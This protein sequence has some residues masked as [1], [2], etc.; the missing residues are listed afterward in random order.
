[1]EAVCED[2]SEILHSSSF[3]PGP[4]KLQAS[5]PGILKALNNRPTQGRVCKFGCEEVFRGSKHRA[6]R[7][8]PA[9]IKIGPARLHAHFI[10]PS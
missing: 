6:T 4:G 7:P 8:S 1:M 9:S 10:V 2:D 5:I 3:Q